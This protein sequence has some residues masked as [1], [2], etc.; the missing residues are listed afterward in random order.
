MVEPP[1][2]RSSARRRERSVPPAFG[3]HHRGVCDVWRYARGVIRRRRAARPGRTRTDDEHE[4]DIS[5]VGPQLNSRSLI[6]KRRQSVA[7]QWKRMSE[8]ATLGRSKLIRERAS[9]RGTPMR[10]SVSR[11]VVHGSSA[12]AACVRAIRRLLFCNGRKVFAGAASSWLSRS[13]GAEGAH[14]QRSDL[15]RA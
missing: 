4:E 9:S 2:S 15:I 5:L 10:R 6:Q 11:S 12:S 14:L 3:R 8:T 1:E 7:K 13:R